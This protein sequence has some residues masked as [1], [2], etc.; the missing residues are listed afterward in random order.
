MAKAGKLTR[1]EFLKGA[2]AA[3]L[4]LA[5]SDILPRRALSQAAGCQ[6]YRGIA[7]TDWDYSARTV[8][9]RRAEIREHWLDEIK[10][11]GA[12]SVEITIPVSRGPDH[13]VGYPTEYPPY[14]EPWDSTVHDE[15]IKRYVRQAQARGFKVILDIPSFL[16]SR[17]PRPQPFDL[18]LFYSNLETMALKWAEIA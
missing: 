13:Q 7:P 15:G 16:G 10:E 6:P 18:D 12:D 1:R 2:G 4:G 17:Y 5:L 8:I 11:L 9:P 14:W 3:A